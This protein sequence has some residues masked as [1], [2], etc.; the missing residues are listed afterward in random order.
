MGLKM[1]YMKYKIKLEFRGKMLEYDIYHYKIEDKFL[2]LGIGDDSGKTCF[3]LDKIDYFKVSGLPLGSKRIKSKI[4]LEFKNKMLE[5]DIYNYKIENKFL[6]IVTDD[7]RFYFD[8]NKVDN[9]KITSV[10]FDLSGDCL[11]FDC[12]DFDYFPPTY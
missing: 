1:E 10:S 3:S 2:A 7:G 9:Y 6:K 11:D 5:Y 4:E 8:I 12:S